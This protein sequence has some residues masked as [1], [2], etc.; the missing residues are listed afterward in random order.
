MIGML[1]LYEFLYSNEA[2]ITIGRGRCIVRMVRVWTWC[3][4][5]CGHYSTDFNMISN[6]F[7]VTRNVLLTLHDYKTAKELWEWGRS[8]TGPPGFKSCTGSAGTGV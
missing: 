1:Y 5:I 4:Q 6:K 8:A 3:N 2:K 7:M